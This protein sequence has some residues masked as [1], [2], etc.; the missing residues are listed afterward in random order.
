MI[1]ECIWAVGLMLAGLGYIF[2]GSSREVV[3]LQYST[4]GLFMFF[5][6]LIALTINIWRYIT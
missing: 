1:L 2:G 3:P 4:V 5:T 6:G